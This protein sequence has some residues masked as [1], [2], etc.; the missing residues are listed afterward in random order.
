MPA[1]AIRSDLPPEELRRLAKLELD[2]RVTRRLLAMPGF[3]V[4]R[5]TWVVGYE[6]SG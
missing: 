3:A 2:A 6:A 1:L 4:T 5:H